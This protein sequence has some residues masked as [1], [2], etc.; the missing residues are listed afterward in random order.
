MSIGNPSSTLGPHCKYMYKYTL[1]KQDGTRLDLGTFKKKKTLAEL[2]SALSC[3]T[4]CII[5]TPYYEG[6]G[7]ATMWGDDDGRFDPSDHRNPHFKVLGG[8]YDVV[9]D[10]LMELKI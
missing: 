7:K 5:P 9:G 4:V 10:V 1:L 3:E 2:Y 6:F 8:D